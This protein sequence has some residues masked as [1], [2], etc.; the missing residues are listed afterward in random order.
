MKE[1][2]N[3]IKCSVHD[4][5]YCDFKINYCTKK[6]I[7]I[8]NCSLEDSKESTMCDSYKKRKEV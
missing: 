6:Q 8:C 2:N 5:K 1:I 3:N 4:C 7:K